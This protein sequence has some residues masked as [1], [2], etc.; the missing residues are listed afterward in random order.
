MT[1][2]FHL[3][4][5][6]KRGEVKMKNNLRKAKSRGEKLRLLKPKDTQGQYITDGE[7]AQRMG[8]DPSWLSR[9]LRDFG[10]PGIDSLMPV[11]NWIKEIHGLDIAV[12]WLTGESIGNVSQKDEP[13]YGKNAPVMRRRQGT[14]GRSGYLGRT[15]NF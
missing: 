6:N 12:Y 2:S 7:W 10:N 8:V 14:P 9:H 15:A 4:K 5:G 1:Y 11:F 13:P 3:V